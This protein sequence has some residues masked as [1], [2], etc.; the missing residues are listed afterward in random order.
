MIPI[1]PKIEG[2]E[3]VEYAKNQPEYLPLPARRD[4]TGMVVTRW[5]LSWMERLKILVKGEFYLQLCTF[6]RPLQ[7]VS[8]SLDRPKT[9]TTR[10]N[11]KY[12]PGPPKPPA[13]KVRM[14]G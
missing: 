8:L 6:N 1:D 2:L 12:I 9:E 14:V 5:K 13:T 7:P 11:G 4:S 3:F 10:Q